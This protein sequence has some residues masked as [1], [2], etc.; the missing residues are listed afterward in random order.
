MIEHFEHYSKQTYRTRTCILTG[1]GVQSLSIPV[2]Q[3]HD[4]ILTK[5]VKIDYKTAWQTNHIRAIQAAYNNSPYFLYYQDY[6]MPFYEKKPT[7]LVDYNTELLQVLLKLLGIKKEIQATTDFVNQ[8]TDALDVRTEIHPKRSTQEDYK[9][10]IS[11]SYQQVFDT[12]FGFTPNL[13]VLDLLCNE[14]NGS[15]RYLQNAKFNF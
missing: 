2:I 4:K 3:T 8:Y 5:D 14:G 10:R 6:L 13:S 15:H 7:F 12:R 1:N 11:E 9:F